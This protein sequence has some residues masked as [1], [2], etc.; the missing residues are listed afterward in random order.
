MQ[1]N[2]IM[3]VQKFPATLGL[4]VI[5]Y[6]PLELDMRNLVLRRTEVYLHIKNEILFLSSLISFYAGC[7][8]AG[9][10]YESKT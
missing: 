8:S 4:M 7:W 1:H 10:Y 9:K 6:K 2:N 3:A 5:T